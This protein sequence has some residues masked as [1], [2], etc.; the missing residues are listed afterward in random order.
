MRT[1][2]LPLLVLTSVLLGTASQ[3]DVMSDGNLLIERKEWAACGAH[4]RRA[5]E[6]SPDNLDYRSQLALCLLMQG[7]HVGADAEI[8]RVIATNT[9]HTAAL[10]YRVL[11]R[12]EQDDYRQT[13]EAI[14]RVLPR[15][16]AESPQFAVAH[17]FVALSYRELLSREG[18]TYAEAERMV[19]AAETYLRVGPDGGDKKA[20]KKWLRWVKK[21]RPGPH[22]Q[23]WAVL[24]PALR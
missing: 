23:T 12:V 7:D 10:W 3:A 22:V 6:T 2:T 19:A 20:L 1:L 9:D 16:S 24:S 21:N 5:L 15:L 13:I 11:N 17:W 18:L 8:D 14:D 4:F